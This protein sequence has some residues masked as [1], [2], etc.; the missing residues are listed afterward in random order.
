MCIRDSP[1]TG[2]EM[3]AIQ[4]Y[5]ASAS[6]R[7]RALLRQMGVAYRLISVAVDETLLPDENPPAYV[8]R[9]A[10]TKAQVGVQALGRRKPCLLYTSR[11]V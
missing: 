9:L 10:R 2:P 3:P 6:P 4:I 11:C 1:I 8:A 7:R 5:L